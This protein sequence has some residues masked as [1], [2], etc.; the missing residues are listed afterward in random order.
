M[1]EDLVKILPP[2]ELRFVVLHVEIDADSVD[3]IESAIMSALARSIHAPGHPLRE[4]HVGRV[5]REEPF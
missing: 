4:V 2:T 5:L 1:S 3:R